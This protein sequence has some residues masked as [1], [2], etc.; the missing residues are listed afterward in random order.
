MATSSAFFPIGNLAP[1][2]PGLPDQADLNPLLT[3]T[4]YFDGRLLTAA[5]LTRDQVYLDQ[6]LREMGQVL[7]AGVARGLE[8]ELVGGRI[9]VR[10]GIGVN[11]AGRVLELQAPW[12]IDLNDR[13]GIAAQN[14]GQ[15][16]HLDHGLYALLLLFAEQD[17]GVAEVFP[18]DL[19]ERTPRFDATLESLQAALMPLPLPLPLASPL[20]VRAALIERQAEGGLHAGMIPDSAVALGVLA[21]REDRPHWLDTRLLRQPLRGRPSMGDSQADMQ[22]AYEAL[23]A[24]I[25]RDRRPLDGDFAATDYFRLLPPT[26]RI[27]KAALDPVAGRQGFFPEHFNVSVAPIRQGDLALVQRESMALPAIELTRDEPLDIVVL[28]PLSGSDF[29]R[30]ASALERQPD[31]AGTGPPAGRA[32][33][34]LLPHLDL[35]ALRL[36]PVRPVHRLDTDAPAWDRLWSAVGE[37]DPVFV[38][39]PTRAAETG[40]SAIRIA[41]G[42]PVEPSA[43]D[44]GDGQPPIDT[45]PSPADTASLLLDADAALLEQVSLERLAGL[46]RPRDDAGRDALAALSR[47][48]ASDAPG[49]LACMDLLILIDQRFDPVIWQTL[50][51]LAANG[52]LAP[53]RGE[54]AGLSASPEG[55]PGADLVAQRIAELGAGLGLDGALI[56]RWRELGADA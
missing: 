5:D 14:A 18:R 20:Q 52:G 26:G 25:L 44:L 23:L 30:L 10:P 8:A 1:P 51:V 19:A 55:T 2:V 28:A 6:R 53:M 24:D 17:Q 4:H 15:S 36:Y 13:V 22:R 49:V 11:A 47:V 7:G 38:R 3:R 29:G 56:D 42:T 39:R 45:T 9:Q 41:A 32:P 35:L 54:L 46:R 48:L 34:R 12:V 16:F 40:I 50:S 31:A 43:P 27:P 21:V 37:T 33:N